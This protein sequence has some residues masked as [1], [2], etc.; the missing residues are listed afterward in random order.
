MAQQVFAPIEVSKSLSRRLHNHVTGNAYTLDA[1]GSALAQDVD[2]S[3][4]LV[5]G[6]TL[7]GGTSAMY[8]PIGVAKAASR[9]V[10]S[11]VTGTT[12]FLDGRG[13]AAVAAAADVAWLKTQ[14]Y[15]ATGQ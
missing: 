12:Y 5:Q 7:T 4:F 2:V 11:P 8:G 14:G 9:P 6:F 1:R 13:G 10:V 15:L 3:W